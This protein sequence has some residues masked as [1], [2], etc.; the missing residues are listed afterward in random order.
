[1]RLLGEFNYQQRPI[2]L[3]KGCEFFKR[4]VADS[5]H[6]TFLK[7]LKESRGWGCGGT[8][9]TRY[10]Q[11]EL[12]GRLGGSNEN[13]ASLLWYQDCAGEVHNFPT[14]EL[15]SAPVICSRCG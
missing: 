11:R 3:D 9:T 15:L 8:E 6:K 5:R 1:M 12:R 2:F 10:L 13:A 14:V 7:N 4:R